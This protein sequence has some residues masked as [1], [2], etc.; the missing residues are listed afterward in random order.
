MDPLEEFPTEVAEMI[1]THFRGRELMQL[2]LVSPGWKTFIGSSFICMK[3]LR[4]A[5][6]GDWVNFT[7][8]DR[9]I[10]L[11]GRKYSDVLISA[12]TE[13]LGIMY[14]IMKASSNW[15]TVRISGTKFSTSAVFIAFLET[16]AATVQD[17]ELYW[18]SVGDCIEA[19]EVTLN[20]GKLKRLEMS[21]C[22]VDV[23]ALLL[24]KS[25]SVEE[26]L[27]F[28]YMHS[29]N[30]WNV[31]NLRNSAF[32]LQ[33]VTTLHLTTDIYN[34]IFRGSVENFKPRLKLLRILESFWI[35]KPLYPEEHLVRLLHSQGV[36][37]RV[38][39]E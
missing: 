32:K 9:K 12:G 22:D 20:F 15:T 26:A 5:L 30:N 37:L 36:Q 18:L 33:K 23:Y 34:L 39:I 24:E 25:P 8:N 29:I 2:S 10:L 7:D 27:I 4:L 14:E 19:Q 11:A 3:K 31:V 6:R 1:F 17:L 28:N 21:C 13:Q 35:L 38:E 16:F